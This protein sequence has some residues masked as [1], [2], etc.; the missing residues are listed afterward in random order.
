MTVE[1]TKE[2]FT[3]WQ[4]SLTGRLTMSLSSPEKIAW[5]A[6]AEGVLTALK[7]EHNRGKSP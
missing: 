5:F 7:A 4:E 3:E 2:A 6:F 1:Q